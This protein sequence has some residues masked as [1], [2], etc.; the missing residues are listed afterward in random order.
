[1]PR[2]S[3]QIIPNDKLG[4]GGLSVVNNYDFS[5]ANPA[6]LTALRQEA[7][8]IKQDTFSAVFSEINRGG[9]DARMS[10]RR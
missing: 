9:S 1:M 7:E 4:G 2:R 6:T 3:G 5:G 8:R 10:G